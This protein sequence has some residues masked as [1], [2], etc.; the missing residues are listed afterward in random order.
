MSNFMTTSKRNLNWY[1]RETGW[2]MVNFLLQTT[3]SRTLIK[4]SKIKNIGQ[5]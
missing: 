4:K 1:N 2:K 3:P 5:E